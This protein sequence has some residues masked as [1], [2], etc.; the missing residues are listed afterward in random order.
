[1]A[2]GFFLRGDLDGDREITDKDGAIVSANYGGSNKTY[3]QGD[4]DY[5]GDVDF[6][7]LLYVAQ[8]NGVVLA[9]PPTSPG[10]LVAYTATLDDPSHEMKLDWTA[11]LEEFDGFKIF[12]GT[13]GVNFTQIADV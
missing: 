3:L 12:R 4:T 6:T 13:D 2:V 11:P 1:V 7:D 10:E 9:E 5:D 8:R